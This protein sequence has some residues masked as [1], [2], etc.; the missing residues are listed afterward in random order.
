M[1]SKMEL[2]IRILV[3]PLWYGCNARCRMC[4]VWTRPSDP[5]W[6]PAALR[7]VLR[8]SLFPRSVQTVN[9][10][11]GEPTLHPL[12]NELIRTILD[13]LPALQ[14]LSLQTNAVDGTRCISALK[15]LQNEIRRQEEFGR[16]IHLDVNISLDGPERVHD[17]I[18]GV[19]G[20]WREAARVTNYARDTVAKLPD[21]SVLLM[22]TMVSANIG[23]LN[24][25]AAIAKDRKTDIIFTIPQVTDIYM[26]NSASP[27][28]FEMTEEQKMQAADFLRSLASRA[29][30]GEAMSHR[31]CM[32][33]L[34][35]LRGG[36][37]TLPCPLRDQGLFLEPN[38]DLYPCWRTAA[39]HLGNINRDDAS[40]ITRRRASQGYQ[41]L[42]TSSCLACSNNCYIEWGRRQFARNLTHEA[43]N[44]VI[45]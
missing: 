17:R 45:S 14:T 41:D 1:N 37:R 32:M 22:C 16:R 13:E 34:N 23:V 42:L 15:V 4:N 20:A 33:L 24:E 3:L 26:Q 27:S 28:R 7:S 2:G 21:A 30:G 11:G 44:K 38:G 40:S 29:R 31:Y 43:Q 18:R 19:T 6:Q 5:G 8:E 9:V 25:I 10:T 39:L 36:E 12:F 35:L